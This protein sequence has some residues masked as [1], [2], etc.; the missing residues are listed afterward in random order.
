MSDRKKYKFSSDNIE[1]FV[2]IKPTNEKGYVNIEGYYK[3]K[4]MKT[5]NH[6]KVQ[7]APMKEGE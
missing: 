3:G 7:V 5:L 4:L 2:I 6:V 1:G